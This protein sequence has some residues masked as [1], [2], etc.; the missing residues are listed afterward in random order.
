MATLSGTS[1]LVNE[2]AVA[3]EIF[4]ESN[5]QR[6]DFPWGCIYRVKKIIRIDVKTP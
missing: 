1:H 6:M 3:L 5:A 2:V 4:L